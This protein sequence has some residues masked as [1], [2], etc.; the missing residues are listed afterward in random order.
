M[1]RKLPSPLLPLTAILTPP[2][3]ASTP[4]D[5]N[6]STRL[7]PASLREVSLRPSVVVKL[8][9]SPWISIP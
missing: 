4:A 1:P 6:V 5:S 2:V 7:E 9:L 3:D 8:S